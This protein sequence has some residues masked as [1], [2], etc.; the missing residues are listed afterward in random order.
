MEAIGD[1]IYEYGGGLYV[2][3]TNRCPCRCE[4]CIRNM[5]DALGQA[6]SLWLKREP[7]VTEVIETL[8][9]WDLG[10]YR[11]LVFC[12]YGEPME[13]LPELLEICR[14]VKE[15]KE[16]RCR[17]NTNGLADLIQGKRT[18]PSLSGWVDA[19]SISLNAASAKK[20]EQ[21]CHP[22]FGERAY[23]AIMDFTSDAKRYVKD[24]TMSVV[25]GTIPPEDIETCR[26]IAA[27]LGVKF[28]VR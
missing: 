10:K 16:L 5:T 3:M 4:F 28:R 8:Q 19:L 21:L 14:C 1:V 13:R 23:E 6:D 18:A 12:G 25:G 26:G 22:I 17:V 20:Y 7:S 27:E 15:Q 9:Q 24:I 11:E 2:N